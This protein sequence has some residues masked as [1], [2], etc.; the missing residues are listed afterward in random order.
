MLYSFADYINFQCKLVLDFFAETNDNT[1]NVN[2][3]NNTEVVSDIGTISVVTGGDVKST[4]EYLRDC[5]PF[6]KFQLR[7]PPIIVK[8]QIYCF[9]HDRDLVDQVLVS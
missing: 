4:L 1:C 7:L 5:F 9:V 8:H 3:I 6:Q 2:G